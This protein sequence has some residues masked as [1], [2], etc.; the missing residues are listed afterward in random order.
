M[1]CNGDHNGVRNGGLIQCWTVGPIFTFGRSRMF[2]PDKLRPSAVGPSR[3]IKKISNM[4]HK[5]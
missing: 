3:M 1:F 5:S 4:C 2:G